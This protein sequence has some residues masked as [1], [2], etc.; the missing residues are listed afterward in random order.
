[1]GAC[2]GVG[3]VWHNPELQ[4]LIPLG[5]CS[6]TGCPLIHSCP[7]GLIFLS[8][9]SAALT[10]R[11]GKDL[12]PCP[13]FGDWITKFLFIFYSPERIRLWLLTKNGQDSSTR[14]NMLA[15]W[16]LEMCH[17]CENILLPIN[18]DPKCLQLC[19]GCSKY[20]WLN[21]H[22]AIDPSCNMNIQDWILD[23]I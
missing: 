11:Y 16:T 12:Q 23:T 19:C 9:F 7:T 8:A 6:S 17:C 15:P 1:M 5:V 18:H 4:L 3:R 21:E 22:L 14:D 2:W 20:W 10:A 13:S